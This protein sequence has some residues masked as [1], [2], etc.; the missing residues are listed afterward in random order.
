VSPVLQQALMLVPDG[1]A[2]AYTLA[3]QPELV[4]RLNQMPPPLVL[5]ELGRLLPPPQATAVAPPA[6]GQGQAAVG[7]PN[8]NGAVPAVPAAPLPEPM[9]PVGGGGSTAQPTYTDG[10]SQAE[11][12]RY[13]ARTSQ[14]PYL[15]RS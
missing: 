8:G 4:Q 2:V 13:R 9:A 15:R 6:Q 14:I 3:R 11:Y 5:L 10:M 7:S 1:P 12:E